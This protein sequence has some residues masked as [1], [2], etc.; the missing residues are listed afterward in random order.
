MKVEKVLD[1]NNHN[2][3]ERE[4]ENFQGGR[5]WQWRRKYLLQVDNKVYLVSLNFFER[6]LKTFCCCF[7]YFQY[8]LQLNTIPK[9]LSSGAGIDFT[10][11]KKNDQGLPKTELMEQKKE[12][13]GNDHEKENTNEAKEGPS[14]VE[15]ITTWPER[16]I[17]DV[18]FKDTP[19]E[20]P[21][22]MNKVL[23]HSKNLTRHFYFRMSCYASGL[24]SLDISEAK[25][26]LQFQFEEEYI[27][28]SLY[29]LLLTGHLTY[30]TIKESFAGSFSYNA[31]TDPKKNGFDPHE[32]KTTGIDWFY[33]KNTESKAK[34]RKEFVIVK[35]EEVLQL[36]QS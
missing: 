5:C 17:I 29:Y 30:I 32:L 33:T 22:D 15:M 24:V 27:L 25:Q 4:T 7:N 34:G 8:R 9:V 6:I 11:V 26:D 36:V 2:E 31:N 10:K 13:A 1:I 23:L 3:C 16:K 35:R 19:K 21:R 20:V 28:P 12:V 18:I 14:Q